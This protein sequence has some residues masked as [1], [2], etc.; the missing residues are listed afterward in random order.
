MR[1]GREGDPAR[2]GR[3]P[4]KGRAERSSPPPSFDEERPTEAPGRPRKCRNQKL[5]VP[6][7]Q[8]TLLP[9]HGAVAKAPTRGAGTQ[10][11][12]PC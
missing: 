12:P 2:G 8:G 11:R 10:T 7:S 4:Q 9:V 3:G 6:G 5:P 1:A